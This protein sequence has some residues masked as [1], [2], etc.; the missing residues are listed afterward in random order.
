MTRRRISTPSADRVQASVA[1]RI[2]SFSASV[3]H[4]RWA[5]SRTSGSG[6]GGAWSDF[7]LVSSGAPSLRSV[8]LRAP[9]LRFGAPDDASVFGKCF[10]NGMRNL[11]A[12][13]SN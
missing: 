9:E 10:A 8:S 11:L 6:G 1:L 2:W 13:Y 12:L 3:Y 5:F 4:R 7:G